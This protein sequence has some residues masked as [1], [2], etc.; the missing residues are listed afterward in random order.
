MVRALF[1]KSMVNRDKIDLAE[2]S[3]VQSPD[4]M[5]AQINK[6][7]IISSVVK[8]WHSCSK[9]NNPYKSQNNINNIA[10]EL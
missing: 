5:L 7:Y 3:M 4:G 2:L 10:I 6:A 8:S 9:W 1:A